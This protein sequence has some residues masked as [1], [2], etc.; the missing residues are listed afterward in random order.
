MPPDYPWGIHI[1]RPQGA[2]TLKITPFS[3]ENCNQDP[4][5]GVSK[6][7]VDIILSALKDVIQWEASELGRSPRSP[8]SL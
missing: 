2:N 8:A 7:N 6:F 5:V 4:Q 1:S 3:L